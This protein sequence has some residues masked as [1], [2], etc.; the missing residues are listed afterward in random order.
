M[1]EIFSKKA[2]KL[3]IICLSFKFP[4][5]FGRSI[6]F[7]TLALKCS[8]NFEKSWWRLKNGQELR[9]VSERGKNNQSS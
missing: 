6:R 4:T 7:S 5:N 8:Q 1:L 9:A 2:Y 3:L